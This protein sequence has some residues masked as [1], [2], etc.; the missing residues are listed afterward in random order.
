[1]ARDSRFAS[2]VFGDHHDADGVRG[3]IARPRAVHKDATFVLCVN[4]DRTAALKAT[5]PDGTVIWFRTEAQ[6]RAV[7]RTHANAAIV[8]IANQVIIVLPDGISGGGGYGGGSPSDPCGASF[9]V[10]PENVARR[11]E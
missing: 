9:V 3:R 2:S 7:V 5:K 11:T 6:I 1:M 8:A 4:R 10:A